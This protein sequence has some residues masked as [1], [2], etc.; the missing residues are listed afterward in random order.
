[1][2]Y[3]FLQ[4][5]RKNDKFGYLC[6]GKGISL[7]H[8]QSIKY[9]LAIFDARAVVTLL[10]SVVIPI[11]QMTGQGNLQSSHRNQGSGA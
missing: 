10:G 1:M 9:S 11:F 4:N 2:D 8:W 5:I 7:Y 6:S 3:Y